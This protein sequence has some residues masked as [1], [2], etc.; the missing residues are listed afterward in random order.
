MRLKLVEVATLL[1]LTRLRL[2]QRLQLFELLR[3]LLELLL[4]PEVHLP[5]QGNHVFLDLIILDPVVVPGLLGGLDTALELDD[6]KLFGTKLLPEH[7]QRTLLNVS[8]HAV[9]A[10]AGLAQLSLQL[11]RILR[12]AF[13]VR[14]ELHSL[15][16]ELLLDVHDLLLFTRQLT[17]DLHDFALELFFKLD[18]ALFSPL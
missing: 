17:A 14:L 8:L 16:L 2:H 6:L 13:L 3:L 10:F 4:L 12:Q 5:L 9:V 15:L 1:L 11:S 18:D 7:A